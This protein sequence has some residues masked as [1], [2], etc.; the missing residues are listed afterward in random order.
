MSERYKPKRIIHGVM[1][2]MLLPSIAGCGGGG[3]ENSTNPTC[4]PKGDQQD[5]HVDD[6]VV[7]C[8]EHPD[9]L[10]CSAGV[11]PITVLLHILTGGC[12]D[13]TRPEPGQTCDSKNK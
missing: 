13:G 7:Y 4:D 2:L 3:K 8:A 10:Q 6:L 1:A 11:A 5:C 9:E 12:E